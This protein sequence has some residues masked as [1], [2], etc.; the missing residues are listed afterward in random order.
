MDPTHPKAVEDPN[1]D[2]E[3]HGFRHAAVR[4]DDEVEGHGF[5]KSAVPEDDDVEG[6][7]AKF[8]EPSA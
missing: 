1:D 6:H 7:G 4:E 3:G 2:V 8:S 5:R